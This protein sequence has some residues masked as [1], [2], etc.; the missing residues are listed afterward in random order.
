MK[1]GEPMRVLIIRPEREATALA[2]ALSERGHAPVIAPF[3]RLEF[4]HPPSDFSAAL[5]ACQA[6]LLTSANGARAFAEASEQRGRPILAVGDTTA[7]TAEGLGFSDVIS[8]SGDFAALADLVRQRLDP[9]G[10]PLIHVAGRDVAFDFA[11]TLAPAGEVKRS[12]LRRAWGDRTAGVGTRCSGGA[13]A[14]R[15]HLLL[16]AV[17]LGVWQHGR[18]RGTVGRPAQRHRRRHR[19]GGAGAGGGPAVQ[20]RLGGSA[21]DATGRA[22]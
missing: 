6:V 17:G 16:T 22:G 12:P 13:R 15:R 3:F 8:A 2:T 5:A 10:G 21:A 20:G 11:E 18:G 7:N 19:R 1:Y 14:R 9:K 4:L